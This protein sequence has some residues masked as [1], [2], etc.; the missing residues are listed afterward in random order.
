M[1]D[2]MIKFPTLIVGLVVGFILLRLFSIDRPIFYKWPS[3]DNAG[4]AK[5]KDKNGICY[6]YA[7]E[8]V[9]CSANKA[10]IRPYPLQV[11]QPYMVMK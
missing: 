5:Y 6:E 4:K 3:P 9:D 7:T 2:F 8:E 11:P 1:P 10:K